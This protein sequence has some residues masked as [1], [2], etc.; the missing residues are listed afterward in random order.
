MEATENISAQVYVL[1]PGTKELSIE[2]PTGGRPWA[3]IARIW[4]QSVGKVPMSY[5]EA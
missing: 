3:A 4:R 2:T 5:F 1:K